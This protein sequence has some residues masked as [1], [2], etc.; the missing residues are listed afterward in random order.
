MTTDD[1]DISRR[2]VLV[3]AGAAAVTIASGAVAMPLALAT[4][5]PAGST[6]T[7][8][9]GRRLPPLIWVKGRVTWFDEVNGFGCVSCS[10]VPFDVLITNDWLEHRGIA[11]LREGTTVWG[12][13]VRRLQVDTG[14]FGSGRDLFRVYKLI[15]I[16]GV[17]H[18]TEMIGPSQKRANGRRFL[19]RMIV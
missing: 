5:A 18:S 9:S 1:K 17:D 7:G 10:N 4:T 14:R 13:A 16:D 6:A 3:G 2:A 8:F 15:F 12:T 11:Q 19:R